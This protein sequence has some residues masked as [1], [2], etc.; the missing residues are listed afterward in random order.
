L[1]TGTSAR[2]GAAIAIMRR[3]RALPVDL[4]EWQGTEDWGDRSL[5]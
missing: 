5:N 3:R 1:L 4:M 2:L